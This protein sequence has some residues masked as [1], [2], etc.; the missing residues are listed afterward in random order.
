MN[1]EEKIR[2]E[3]L[4]EIM[5][6]LKNNDM[7]SIDKT[8]FYDFISKNDLCVI[9]FWA[10]WCAPCHI[11]SPLVKDLSLKYRNVKFA[12]VNGDEN[13]ELLYQYQITGLPT[14]LYFKDGILVNRSVGVVPKNSLEEKLKWLM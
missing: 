9:D 5:D 14:V 7:I 13:M 12:K 11:L 8:N 1:E 2:Q 6:S 3:K 4:K 10:P